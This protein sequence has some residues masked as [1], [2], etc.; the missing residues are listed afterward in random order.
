MKALARKAVE[1]PV[2]FLMTSLIVIGFGLFGLS[3]LRLNL[4]P[5]VSFPTITVYTTY[6]GV[7]P[8][9]I[10]T[11][12][13]RPIE[14]AVGS[15][16]GVRRVRSISN[17]GASVVKLKFNWGTDL[18][19][20][21]S[22]VR[23]EL[24]FVRRTIPE[25]AE[26][27]IVF[28]YD[29]NQEPIIVLTLTS[30]IRSPR[31]IRTIAKQRLEQRLERIPGVAS[32]ETSGGYE[33]QINID[34]SNE[35][36]RSYDLSISTIASK[37]QQE[38]IQ[39]PAGELVEGRTIYSLRTIGE[40]ENVDQIRNTIIAVRD[41]EP[42]RLS[43]VARV[44]DGVAQPI[45][46]VHV[47][48]Q[49]GVIINV[50]RQ[51]DANVVTTANSVVASLDDME[52]ILPRDVKIDVLTNEAN[53][54]EMSI[55]NLLWTGLQAVILVVLILLAFLHSGRSALIIA[56]SIPVSIISTFSIM[57]WADLSL[58]IISLSGL[59]LAVGMVVDDAVV[60]LENIFRFKEEGYDRDKASI[61][62]AQEVAVPV[63]ISTLTTLVV[64]IPILFV[65]G[66]AGFL[67]RDLALTISFALSVSSIVALSLIPM[68]SSQLLDTKGKDDEDSRNYLRR[69]LDWSRENVYKRI[70]ASPLLLLGA[71]VYPFYLLF[72]FIG[73]K[74]GSFFSK[75]VGPA[76]GDF[77]Q[78]LET[79]Y[80]DT[81]DR[82]L[83]RSGFVVTSAV[84]LFLL[85]LPIFGFLGGEFFPKVDD[86]G[87]ILDVQ[88]DPG[89]SLLE[90][91]RTISQ[92]ESII[93]REVPEAR[94]VVSDFGDKE[95]IEGADNPGG[96]QGTVRVELVPQGERRRSEADITASLLE[97][98]E[99]VPG[100]EIKEV[101]QDPLSPEGEN[102]L[103]VQIFGY[104]PSVKE[105]LAN[106]VK[107]RLNE[108]DG[109]VNV[110]STADQGRPELRVRMDRERISRIGMNTQQVASAISNAVQGNL[111]TTYVDQGIEFEVR[112][113]LKETDKASVTD[114]RNLQVETPDG[115]WVPLSNL[116]TVER[117]SGPTNILRVNQER[118]TEVTADLSTI[119]MN[120]AT[121]R[122]QEQLSTI[123]WP[124]GYRYQ[125]A[126][127]AEDQ[128][129]SFN[130]L[131][132]AFMIAGILT[133][134]VM[135]SQFE[136]LMEPFI[137]ILTIPLA[138]TGVLLI[139]WMTGTSISVTSMVG[140]ILLSGI[141]V[142]NGI[143]MID[144]IKILQ[145]RKMTR[146]EAIVEGASR[147][148]RP[149]LMTALTTVLSMVPLALELGSGSE[150]WSPM[151]RTV[152]GGLTVSTLLMLF[153]VP[154]LYNLINSM[155]ENLGF[156]SIH[157]E[158]PLLETE[159][160]E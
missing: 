10:E 83:H 48:N 38:N 37:L 5:D 96:Y 93:E 137:I 57:D 125:I 16:S 26:Q 124:D 138:L 111:A 105:D 13:T 55:E 14:E 17:Q 49:E 2:T 99:I 24:D 147:R 74:S 32:S 86:N 63:V 1:R 76:I 82:F 72:K 21:E 139:L 51:S 64:F 84:L 18:Y 140:L 144:Y 156:D 154:C 133:Y 25:D 40:F 19:I 123:D 149:I 34:I 73:K 87:F 157:K 60:V 61:F 121:N 3:N 142:N 4:Y 153:V 120:T 22:D 117:Y 47:G 122:T 94:L 102:G 114:L 70:I 132:I 131:M 69:L 43:D 103:I 42:L 104:E 91:E 118:V 53:F 148:L 39:V 155:V 130:Y 36:M 50:Y 12:V 58:N 81:L 158:D 134:M 9:D 98:L 127:S 6:E 29:P 20:A 119:D 141:V 143:V 30:D 15:I 160:A 41:G 44:E 8:E 65:P 78:R 46:N 66:I 79:S 100:A 89:V 108:I 7:A 33:R 107:A 75:T 129:D 151:A 159:L 27:P 90:L 101:Q 128:Q 135:A 85:T 35:Q 59:T 77:L 146:H 145:A 23:K 88:R 52:N 54:I 110:F 71:L 106:G 116:A 45:G 80:K 95:G 28:S 109:I 112:V 67:F 136:S 92:V 11:L 152:I 31:E 115:G 113:Q 62:G 68:M 97:E 56:I 150:T 126:G